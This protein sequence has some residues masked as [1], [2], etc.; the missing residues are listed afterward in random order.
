MTHFER[1]ETAEP[2]GITDV[3]SGLRAAREALLQLQR[4]V[5][6]VVGTEPLSPFGPKAVLL[7]LLGRGEAFHRGTLDPI[8]KGNPF[9][10]FTL[11]RA[12][13][14]NVTALVW[15]SAYPTRI[16]RLDPALGG[17]PPD[18]GQMSNVA[19]QGTG[20]FREIY[21]QLSAFAHPAAAGREVTGNL[22]SERFHQFRD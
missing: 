15:I 18:A 5:V 7:G 2:R 12:Y 19:R 16:G 8:K 17:F 22:W 3:E 20:G 6:R 14:K 21:R 13:A 11:L 1:G 4:H 9:A 10:T